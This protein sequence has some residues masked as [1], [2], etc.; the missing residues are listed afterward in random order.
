MLSRDILVNILLS[1]FI[2]ICGTLWVYKMTMEDEHMTARETTMTFTCFVF[3][4]MFNALSSRSQEKLISEIGFFS[5]RVFCVAVAL[6]IL[7]QLAVIY[8]PPLQY[9]FQTEALALEDLFLLTGLSSSVF[10]ICEAKKLIQR[11]YFSGSDAKRST[12]RKSTSPKHQNP[13]LPI[14]NGVFRSKKLS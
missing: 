12:T 13:L 8:L 4:D 3:F 9:I 10:I 11:H 7:G 1:A 6:S 2:I 14:T 5:N